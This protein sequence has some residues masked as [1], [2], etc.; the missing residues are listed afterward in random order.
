MGRLVVA[1]ETLTVVKKRDRVGKD[2]PYLW[3]YGLRI[4]TSGAEP[5]GLRF[6]MKSDPSSGNM[7]AQMDRGD[8]RAIPATV[9][10]FE[11]NVLPILGVKLFAGF[12]CVA[13]EQD[14]TPPQSMRIAYDEVAIGLN[15][16][17]EQ[18][19]ASLETG[20]LTA[21]ER[22]TLSEQL[23]A[24]A[25]ARIRQTWG[26]GTLN[27][28]DEIDTQFMFV[29]LDGDTP[30]SIPIRSTFKRFGAEYRIDGRLTYT[31]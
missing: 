13:W 30:A 3:V 4:D 16:F 27:Y 8:R 31:P 17:I 21:A 10:R 7:G 1:L 2:E 20:P 9:G 14:R 5:T 25:R 18:R 24:I 15:T 6:V 29:E 28:D 12:V 23:G 22:D 26:V 19:A 11:R